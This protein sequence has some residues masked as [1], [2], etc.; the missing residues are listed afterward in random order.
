MGVSFPARV[1]I[2]RNYKFF[3][4]FSSREMPVFWVKQVFGRAGRPEYDEYGIGLLLARNE[5]QKEE[6]EEK[7]IG[8]EPEDIKSQ[9]DDELMEEQILA[10]VVSGIHRRERIHDF[11]NSTFFS[12]QGNMMD[13]DFL[14]QKLQRDGFVEILKDRIFPTRFGELVSRLYL[15]PSSALFLRDALSLLKENANDFDLSILVCACKEVPKVSIQKALE[16]SLQLVSQDEILGLC[17]HSELGSAIVLHAWMNELSYKEMHERFGVYPGE[18]HSVVS[19]A[20]WI[21]YAASRISRFLSSGLER[22]LA[23]LERRIRYGVLEHHLALASIPGIG[24]VLSARLYTAG[25]RKPSDI[26][27]ADERELARVFGIGKRRA[28]KLKEE[29]KHLAYEDLRRRKRR[30]KI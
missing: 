12:A 11:F 8:K 28:R 5:E 3:D 13:V 10:T 19:S 9:F 18:V 29:I 27:R 23:I 25:Y 6:L 17:D 20:E 2:I 16:I 21:S 1:A 14:L 7:Y 30:E 26:I 15:S 22:K 4:G 24:R